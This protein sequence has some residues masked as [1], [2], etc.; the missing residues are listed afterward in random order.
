MIA[1]RKSKIQEFKE[2]SQEL[3]FV[4]KTDYYYYPFSASKFLFVDKSTWLVWLEMKFYA[5]DPS[6]YTIRSVDGLRQY[7]C[8]IGGV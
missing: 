6:W 7:V 5:S 2:H 4:E 8:K 1:I 3:G